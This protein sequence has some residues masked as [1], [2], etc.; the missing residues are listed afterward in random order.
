VPVGALNNLKKAEHRRDRRVK[1]T[2]RGRYMLSDRREFP[3]RTVD[4]SA[5]GVAIVG[6]AKGKLGERV[7][8]YLDRIGRLEG[9]VVRHFPGGFAVLL[10]AST[11][12]RDALN[13]EIGRFIK[14]QTPPQSVRQPS[15]VRL[16]YDATKSGTAASL[17]SA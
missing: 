6:S 2:L 13:S 17:P 3:C 15:G 14:E 7:V 10:H 1:V 9:S 11:L 5:G 16:A 12:K 8:V 4:I